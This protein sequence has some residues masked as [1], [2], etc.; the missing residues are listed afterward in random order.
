M[1]TQR[2]PLG[3]GTLSLL[4]LLMGLAFNF[5]WGK[6]NFMISHYLLNLINIPIYSNGTQGLHIP[7]VVAALFWIPT[8]WIA[9]KNRSHY[10][11]SV[12]C[13]VAAFMLVFCIIGPIITVVDWFVNA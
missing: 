7:F 1:T 8:I 2:K 6:T 12:A 4:V 9:K 11:T 13:N 5:Q 10:G 3:L